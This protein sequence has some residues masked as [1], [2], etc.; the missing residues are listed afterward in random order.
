MKP[1]KTLASI[2]VILFAVVLC[3]VPP[4]SGYPEA[5][6][7]TPVPAPAQKPD[8]AK[9]ADA[10]AKQFA[11]ITQKKNQ[12]GYESKQVRYRAHT[13]EDIYRLQVQTYNTLEQSHDLTKKE[14]LKNDT[15]RGQAIILTKYAKEQ[16]RYSQKLLKGQN[17]M[18]RTLITYGQFKHEIEIVENFLTKSAYL[19]SILGLLM[20]AVRVGL[21]E[22]YKR[23]RHRAPKE[24][25]QQ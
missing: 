9:R 20:F 6:Y 14:I 16:E 25:L 8:T 18:R 11:L 24:N 1:T 21:R 12:I 23:N 5:K 15:L 10:D 7:Q 22:W 17:D 3:F 4:R 19:V 13:V 2:A